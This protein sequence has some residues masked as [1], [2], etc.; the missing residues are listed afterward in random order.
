MTPLA[1]VGWVALAGGDHHAGVVA[2]GYLQL[3]AAVA[4]RLVSRA[5]PGGALEAAP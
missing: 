2:G 4:A 5:A 1:L 3:V